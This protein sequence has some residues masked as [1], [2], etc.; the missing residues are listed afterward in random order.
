MNN[1]T[2]LDTYKAI[3]AQS[4]RLCLLRETKK[5]TAKQDAEYIAA[6]DNLWAAAEKVAGLCA[7]SKPDVPAGMRSIM[8]EY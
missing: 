6:I 8:S 1:P 5:R 2:L 4:A 7:S 3:R